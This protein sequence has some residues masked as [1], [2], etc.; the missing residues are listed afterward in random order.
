MR[1]IVVHVADQ[2]TRAA[3]IEDEK[4]VEFYVERD[5]DDQWVGNI[6]VGR[7]AN[8]LPGMQAA[9]VDIGSEKNA[10][11]YIDDAISQKQYEDHDK[12]W[13]PSIREILHEGQEIL[14]QV[15]KKRL[16]VRGLE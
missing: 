9:F 4:L 14:V 8:V 13:N 7:V 2:E 3:V 1:K 12:E 6:Y 5:L 15:K 10:F 11:L 16:E